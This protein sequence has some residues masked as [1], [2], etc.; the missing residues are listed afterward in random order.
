[1]K[2][3][4]MYDVEATWQA[5]RHDEVLLGAVRATL[6]GRSEYSYGPFEIMIGEHKLLCGAFD[7]PHDIERCCELE[8]QVLRL[9]EKYLVHTLEQTKRELGEFGIEIDDGLSSP[10]TGEDVRRTGEGLDQETKG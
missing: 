9:V 5:F 6:Q 10:G 1:M 3:S 2:L 4:R 7:E 8:K